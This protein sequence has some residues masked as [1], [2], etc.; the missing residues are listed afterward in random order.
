MFDWDISSIFSL[1]STT[2]RDILIVYTYHSRH[3]LPFQ[4][5]TREKAYNFKISWLF[6][7]SQLHQKY[8]FELGRPG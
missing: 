3:N 7:F 4:I 6:Q 5:Q 1:L 8:F 2:F